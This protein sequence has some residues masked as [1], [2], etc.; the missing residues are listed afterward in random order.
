VPREQV[1]EREA[2]ERIDGL[3]RDSVAG[4]AGVGY[5]QAGVALRL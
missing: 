2:L 5:N 1:A 3:A 4:G